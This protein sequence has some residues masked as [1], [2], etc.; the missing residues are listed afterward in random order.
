ML[1][2]QYLDHIVDVNTTLSNKHI[3]IQRS[4]VGERAATNSG[5]SL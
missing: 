3:S 1:W 4:A 2:G 5:R